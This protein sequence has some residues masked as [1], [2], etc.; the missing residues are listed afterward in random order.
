MAHSDRERHRDR[1][2]GRRQFDADEPASGHRV[3]RISERTREEIAESLRAVDE[4]RR[5]LESQH[6]AANRDIVR[7]LRAAADEIYD[8]INTLDEIDAEESG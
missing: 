5:L 3:F 1:D 4:A 2:P 7:A 8:V 6:N